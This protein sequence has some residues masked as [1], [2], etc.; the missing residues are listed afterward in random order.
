MDLP[1]GILAVR[2]QAKMRTEQRS[3]R[4]F[5]VVG[6]DKPTQ[7]AVVSVHLEHA[8]GPYRFSSSQPRFCPPRSSRG[9]RDARRDRASREAWSGLDR[10]AG[11]LPLEPRRLGVPDGSVEIFNLYFE[12]GHLGLLTRLL[13]PNRRRVPRLGLDVQSHVT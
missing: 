4:P 5:S 10:S 9:R 6:N 2:V 8:D 1:L 12:V 13:G 11:A 3:R 7:F